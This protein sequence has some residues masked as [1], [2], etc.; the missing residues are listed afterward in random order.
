MQRLEREPSE[1]TEHHQ[2]E[3]AEPL[4][5]NQKHKIKPELESLFRAQKGTIFFT[6]DDSASD[7]WQTIFKTQCNRQSA[8]GNRP[9]AGS[10]R[11]MEA[12]TKK[13]NQTT[14]TKPLTAKHF[15]NF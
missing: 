14:D 5:H 13:H 12:S 1:R 3:A 11:Q 15:R 9:Q 7:H 4:S 6:F 8:I 10:Q 2:E